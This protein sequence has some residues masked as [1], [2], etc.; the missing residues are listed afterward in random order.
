MNIDQSA[1]GK[2]VNNYYL[3]KK[4]TSSIQEVTVTLVS[5]TKITS[6]AAL[7]SRIAAFGFFILMY[8]VAAGKM[9]HGNDKPKHNT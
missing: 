1:V 9:T 5:P 7:A 6:K 8:T 4:Q 3:Q 2:F